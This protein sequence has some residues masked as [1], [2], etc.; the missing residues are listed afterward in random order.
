MSLPAHG[1][2]LDFGCGQGVFTK[3]L[4]DALPGWDVCG[5]ELS[6]IALRKAAARLPDCAFVNSIELASA[7]PFDFIFT[8]HVL[9]HV[10]DLDQTLAEVSRVAAPRS[11][12]CHILPCGNAGSLEH[13]LASL[14]TEGIQARLGNRFFFE[15]EGHLRRLT[16]R[17]LTDAATRH[18]WRLRSANFA[19][20]FW[21]ALE[22][23]TDLDHSFGRTLTSSTNARDF[24]SRLALLRWR[25]IL[26]GIWLA[27]HRSPLGWLLRRLSDAEWRRRQTDPAGSEMYLLFERVP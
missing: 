3:V 9:E 16:S 7:P 1:R 4:R 18:G 24:R 2:A 5:T 27:K 11:L 19:N 22:W 10:L 6:E 14:H 12:M 15:D 17:E 25:V 8:H 23:I 26:S 21:G 20:H 13:Q